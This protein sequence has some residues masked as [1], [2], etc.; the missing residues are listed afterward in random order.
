MIA[1]IPAI[2]VKGTATN[3]VST[4]TAAVLEDMC[5]PIRVERKSHASVVT[6]HAP[7]IINR[8]CVF[9]LIKLC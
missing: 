1:V 5:M 3:H 9:T 7:G 4:V 2:K 6:I 8:S